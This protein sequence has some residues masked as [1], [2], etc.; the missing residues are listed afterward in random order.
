MSVKTDF[1]ESFFW[2][3]LGDALKTLSST[4]YHN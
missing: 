1:Y 2:G 3:A 4:T